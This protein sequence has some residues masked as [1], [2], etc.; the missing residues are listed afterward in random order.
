[1]SSALLERFSWAKAENQ[2]QVR[3]K[4]DTCIFRISHRRFDL[5]QHEETQLHKKAVT[6][7][8]ATPDIRTATSSQ[9]DCQRLR[10]LIIHVLDIVVSGQA[11][12]SLPVI[13]HL[14][15]AGSTNKCFQIRATLIL[16][17]ERRKQHMWQFTKS[18]IRSYYFEK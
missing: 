18:P 15:L 3:C 5:K 9:T 11:S 14:V 4:L 2:D 16:S 1:M 8:A 13:R 17:L 12:L 7:R 10:A 6:A